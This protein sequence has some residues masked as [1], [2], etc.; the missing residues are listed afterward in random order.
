MD[1][2]IF[3]AINELYSWAPPL[4]TML[5]RPEAAAILAVLA[6]VG[7]IVARQSRWLLAAGLAVGICDP[8]CS[9]VIKPMLGRERPCAVLES[10]R[11]PRETHS[12]RPHCGTG[13]SAPSSHAA[14]SAALAA[15]LASPPLAIVSLVVGFSRVVN[16]QHWPSDVVLG[17]GVGAALGASVRALLKRSLGWA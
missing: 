11:G 17:W 7:A 10:V 2:A 12:A 4:W 1:E 5:A 8:L 3:V 13:P 14:N 6:I 15:S 16:G 9:L